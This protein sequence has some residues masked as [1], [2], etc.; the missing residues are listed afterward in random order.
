VN[1]VNAEKEKNEKKNGRRH[2]V[3]D[4]DWTL[5]QGDLIEIPER[6]QFLHAKKT[7]TVPAG[8]GTYSKNIAT[9]VNPYLWRFYRTW[10]PFATTHDGASPSVVHA[11]D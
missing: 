11:D 4:A 2:A 9:C 5:A 10:H 7:R 8:Q 3:A 1:G 6:R